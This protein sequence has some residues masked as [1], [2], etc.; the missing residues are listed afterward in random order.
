MG[1]FSRGRS[2]VATAEFTDE[3][4]AATSHLWSGGSDVATAEFTDQPPAA[5]NQ[6]WSAASILAIAPSFRQLT[7]DPL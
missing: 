4:P 3:P 5:T 1:H 2:V 7:D 6:V